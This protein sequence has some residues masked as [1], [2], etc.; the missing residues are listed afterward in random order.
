[1]S[2]EDLLHPLLSRYMSAAPWLRQ[3]A[4]RVYRHLPERVRYGRRYRHYVE[5]A[6]RSADEVDADAV[7]RRLASTLDLAC[8]RVPAYRRWRYLAHDR[9]AAW[10]RLRELPLTSKLDIKATPS[11]Y[12]TDGVLSARALR[13]FTGGSTANPML[14]YLERSVSRP[15]ETAYMN[16]IDDRMLGRRPDHWVLSLRG[17]TVAGAAREDGDWV[18]VEPIKR[19]LILSSDHLEPR[20]MHRYVEALR[21]W[22]PPLVHA[23]P[24]ALYPLARWLEAHPCPEFTD[25]VRGILLTSENVYRDQLDCFARV[26]AAR[27]VCHYGHSERVLM[28][29]SAA[30]GEPYRFW[31]LYGWLELVDAQG[32]PIEAAGVVGEIVG[33]SFDNGVMPFVRYRTGDL[34]AWAEPPTPGRPQRLARID[35]RLQEFVVCSDHRL[36]SITTL[37]AAHFSELADAQ[38]IQFFQREPGRLELRLVAGAPLTA[39][40]TA[41]VAAAVRAKTQGGC[42]VTVVQVE[43]LYRTAR[44][45]QPLLLQKIDLAPYFGSGAAAERP[46][47]PADAPM[48]G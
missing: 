43:S 23:F 8:A 4:G 32:R 19:H 22:R 6:A 45:K 3:A 34:G 35:G 17:R 46:Q 21:R 18:A 10:E 11:A 36:V 7:E 24:S 16:W 27:I 30:P 5:E 28:G 37:G 12:L 39:R 14:F 41:A 26:F 44:G 9:R 42:E 13:T 2:I 1:M 47:A 25:G 31:P 20:F 48:A 40:A 29:Q 15:R 33:T 38:S